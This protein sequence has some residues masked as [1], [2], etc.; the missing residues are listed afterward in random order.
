MSRPGASVAA[1]ALRRLPADDRGA[2]IVEML[3]AFPV[4]FAFFATI[5]QL[6]YLEVAGLATEHA[7]TV[8]ARAAI[9]VAADD[10]RF[11]GTGTGTLDGQR[12]EEVDEAV[13]NTLRLA[14]D[15][16]TA[17]T[18]F[19][20]FA[21]GTI[22]TAEVTFDYPCTIPVGSVIVCGAS[23]TRHITR[24]AAMPS[25]TASYVYP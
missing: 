5:V 10:P 4:F 2:A 25:Q 8:A 3:V 22:V 23:R 20:G 15:E 16:P 13:H 1:S 14:T 18:K 19:S 9:V 11:Y 6:A 7:A 17:H 24:Q 21:E 12:G